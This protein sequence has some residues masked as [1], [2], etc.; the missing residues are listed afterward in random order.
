M[1]LPWGKARER[2]E[3]LEDRIEELEEER[4]SLRKRFEAEKDR[5]SE[6]SRKKQEAEEQLNRMKDRLE[7]LK[8]E[9]EEE[10]PTDTAVFSS[11]EFDKVLGM[12][13]KLESV[14]SGE[15]DMLTVFSPGEVGEVED[16]KGLKNAVDQE[17]MELLQRQASF[18]A[19]LD[20]SLFN[21]VLRTRPFFEP[22]WVLD[23]GFSVEPILDFI[24]REK[25]WV[26]VSAGE[27]RIFRESA[28][29]TEELE[30]IRNRVDHGH[31]KGG[32]S[33]GRFERKREEQVEEHLQEVGELLREYDNVYLL[34]E[35]R[36]CKELP[37]ERLGG[38]DPNL[39]AP[40]V[41]YNFRGN[42]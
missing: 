42:L 33:Q 32:Y 19:F 41:F 3:D 21:L 7:S 12:L 30:A 36:L 23:T 17:Q 22:G 2:I 29:E 15:K 24:H 1:R 14:E 9:S 11:V 28:G 6:L 40:D 16:F 35:E 8:A 10:E 38:F 13:D 27:T 39:E 5:R 25:T 20:S 37:G 18:V 31:S 4:D 26:L 34:G